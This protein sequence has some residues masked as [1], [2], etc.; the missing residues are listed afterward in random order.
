MS[1]TALTEKIEK[2][3]CTEFFR[4][5]GC[6]E[7][8]I[9]IGSKIKERVDFMVYD[10]YNDVF[11]CFEI[12]VSKSDFKS[13]A[14]KSFVGHYNYYVMPHE[15]FSEVANEI[16]PEIGV[17]IARPSRDGEFVWL[18]SIKKCKKKEL[19][20]EE[21]TMLKDSLI[22]SLSRDAN[23]YYESQSSNAYKNLKKDCNRLYRL[24]QKERN[25]SHNAEKELSM[26]HWKL[27]RK[28][29]KDWEEQ[30][31]GDS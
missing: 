19:T 25:A 16:P 7:V 21:I 9:G 8:S 18:E 1:K 2:A 22:R 5:Y 14:A 6:L 27:R 30:L 29:G 28:L 4:Q 23:R 3:L 11:K 26:L 24:W 10:H 15:L 12:K 20:S 31:N 13:S 17:Y